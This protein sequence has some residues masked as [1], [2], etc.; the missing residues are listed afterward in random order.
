[1]Q[2]A[3]LTGPIR[4][5]LTLSDGTVVDVRPDLVYVD[6]V[7]Q[8]A[9]LAHLIGLHY[10]DRGHPHHDDDAPFVYDAPQEG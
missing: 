7:E 4:T 2:H 10:A 1:M 9:E 8:A 5:T 6:T 3:V